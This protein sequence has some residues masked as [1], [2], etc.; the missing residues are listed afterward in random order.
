[1]T[2][3]AGVAYAD[4]WPA[5]PVHL[6]VPYPPGGPS[7]AIAR[8][9]DGPLAR[10]LGQQVV[11]E[12]LGGASGA[13]AAQKVLAAPAD[14]HYLFQGTVNEVILAPLAHA[15][16]ALKSEDFRLVHPV[17]DGVLVFLTRADL[18]V[19]SVDALIELAAKTPQRPLTY[20]SVGIGSL[21]HLV[22]ED[23]QQRTGIRLQHVP[24]HGNAPLLQD[25]AG[26]RIDFA[27]LAFSAAMGAL[28][29]QGRIKVI[30]QLGEERSKL[31]QHVPTVSEGQA[32]KNFSYRIWSG[33]MVPQATPELVVLSL[34]AA[35]G[36][37][38]QEPAV[39]AQLAAQT[40]D[41]AAPMSLAEA[42]R[43][44]E[45]ETARY[46]AIAKAIKLRPQ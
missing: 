20:G 5:R 45:S 38:L 33:L 42:S 12:N 19:D 8:I 7:D 9:V 4:A 6:M 44:F 30:G 14:G 29:E 11:V 41:T 25:I 22:L 36:N 35:I 17:V 13:L 16:V 31:L 1:M 43:F 34:H 3:T 23:V 27:V 40:H 24:H 37:V 18:P 15:S 32:L 46:R 39:R 10:E 28:V 26:G 2:K 21:Y